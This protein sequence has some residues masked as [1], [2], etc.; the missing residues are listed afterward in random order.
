MTSKLAT[1]FVVLLGLPNMVE[2]A[3]AEETDSTVSSV[4]MTYANCIDKVNDLRR[5]AQ[6]ARAQ[7]ME[8]SRAARDALT[9]SGALTQ[10]FDLYHQASEFWAKAASANAKALSIT[11]HL[12][13][14]LSDEQKFDLLGRIDDRMKNNMITD[15]VANFFVSNSLDSLSKTSKET[16]DLLGKLD[17]SINSVRILGVNNDVS[18][19]N[20]DHAGAHRLGESGSVGSANNADSLGNGDAGAHRLGES[21]SLGSSNNAD[22]LGNG[23]AGA[24]RLGESGSLG[25]SNND[26]SLGNDDAGANSLGDSNSLGTSNSPGLGG[27]SRP[28]KFVIFGQVFFHGSG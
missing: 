10:W 17:H 21:G 5:S 14:P 8:L 4:L 25:T 26:V 2:E 9:A 6:E 1:G 24:H 19:G 28:W 20:G 11:C 15:P 27:F 12:D 13:K 3:V 18:L 16:F 23:D 7:G 22:N